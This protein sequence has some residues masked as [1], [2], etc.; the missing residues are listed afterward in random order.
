MVPEVS[1]EVHKCYNNGKAVRD[2][3]T[4]KLL[5][6]LHDKE[7]YGLHI[8]NLKYY[9]EKGVVF[10]N[11]H[12]CIKLYQSD[13]LKECIDFNTEKGKEATNEFD[14]D[15]LKFMNNTVYGKTMEDVRGHVD[16]ELVD[17]P[18]RMEQLLNA[19]TLKHKQM[20]NED[21]VGV[22][23]IKPVMKLN[24]PI[25]IGVSILG[26]H[27]LHMYQFYYDAMKKK[28]DDKIKLI[29]TDTDSFIF[30]TET[31]HCYKDFD[32]LKG[33]V[34]FSGYD[35]SNPCYDSTNKKVL[36]KFKDE[37]DG[38]TVVQHIGLKPNCIVAKLMI[39]RHLKKVKAW[40][41]T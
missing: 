30:H 26:L 32:D 25:Y 16:S 8:R 14:K 31:E 9:S 41:E 4:Y 20:L 15:L 12:R 40:I 28:Y 27:Q 23:K 17:T 38:K 29:Y 3:K 13:W 21:L 1:K 5:L 19:P 18:E 36:G 39:E 37:L 7:E 22:E 10:K 34:D 33:H 35:K 6:A 11:I 24:K 2:E